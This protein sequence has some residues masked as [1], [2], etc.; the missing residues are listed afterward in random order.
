[1]GAGHDKKTNQQSI[2]IN[3]A[4]QIDEGFLLGQHKVRGEYV[5]LLAIMSRSIADVIGDNRHRVRLK[6]GGR[7][8]LVQSTTCRDRRDAWAWLGLGSNFVDFRKSQIPF[9]A[10]W[11]CDMTGL[12]LL[13]IR[14]KVRTELK[15]LG[16]EWQR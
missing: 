16:K 9:T 4:P 7:V 12:Q 5:L 6:K 2:M 10:E 13:E 1:M 11:V 3:S 8:A 14:K 15:K